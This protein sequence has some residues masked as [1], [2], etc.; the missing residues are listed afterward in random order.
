[1]NR[2]EFVQS[3]VDGGLTERQA[4]AFYRRHIEGEHREVAATAMDLT[5]SNLDNAEREAR[6]KI[7]KAETLVTVVRGA[8]YDDRRSVAVCASCDNP[9]NSLRPRP[10]QD[11]VPMEDWVLVCDDCYAD[12]KSD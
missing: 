11:D 12:E 10:G 3:A 6:S 1:M 5:P 4:E 9:S 2:A 7:R 8:G